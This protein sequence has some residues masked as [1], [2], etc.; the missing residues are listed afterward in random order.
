VTAV[1]MC[2]MKTN[3]WKN[4]M[5]GVK[6]EDS[7]LNS[8]PSS[9]NCTHVCDFSHGNTCFYSVSEVQIHQSMHGLGPRPPVV[10]SVVTSMITRE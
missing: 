3:Y 7:E 10:L 9:Y 5:C 2:I 8:V 1:R 6:I 4:V